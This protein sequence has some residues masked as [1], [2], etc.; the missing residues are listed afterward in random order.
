[1]RG[2]GFE[3]KLM[4]LS[5][6]GTIGRSVDFKA[7]ASFE[8]YH[9]MRAV[10]DGKYADPIMRFVDPPVDY[11]HEIIREDGKYVVRSNFGAETV[12]TTFDPSLNFLVTKVLRTNSGYSS[13]F[14]VIDAIKLPNGS[15]IPKKTYCYFGYRADEFPRIAHLWWTTDINCKPLIS[16]LELDLAYAFQL[17][18]PNGNGVLMIHPQEKFSPDVL[19]DVYSAI[20]RGSSFPSSNLGSAPEMQP[21]F[22]GNSSVPLTYVFASVAFV[23]LITI[24]ML[25]WFRRNRCL[26]L[27]SIG[28]VVAAVF[29]SLERVSA[30]EPDS[31]SI[32]RPSIFLCAR[33]VYRTLQFSS[34][35]GIASFSSSGYQLLSSEQVL[36]EL[37]VSESMRPEILKAMESH[38]IVL[39]SAIRNS[40]SNTFI[41]KFF[42]ESST[43]LINEEGK[44]RTLLSAKQIRRLNQID[45]YLALRQGGA[46][47]LIVLLGIGGDP[48]EEVRLVEISQH[49]LELKKKAYDKANQIWLKTLDR[50]EGH[51]SHQG[52]IHDWWRDRRLGFEDTIYADLV[53]QNVAKKNFAEFFG[54]PIHEIGFPEVFSNSVQL[55]SEAD[56]QWS[57][58]VFRDMPLLGNFSYLVSTFHFQQLHYGENELDL[59]AE[60]VEALNKVSEHVY[61][62][63][64]SIPDLKQSQFKQIALKHISDAWNDILLPRQRDFVVDLIRGQ[65]RT[66][67]G[68]L[69]VLF[70][71]ELDEK[72]KQSI[73]QEFDRCRKQL[74]EIEA[75][76]MTDLLSVLKKELDMPNLITGQA[77]PKYLQPSLCLLELHLI[78]KG[79]LPRPKNEIEQELQKR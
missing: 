7:T 77:R 43:D 48:I 36:S 18:R 10:G 46:E 32:Y 31:I 53:C 75:Q 54:E 58:K 59:S 12:A 71:P 65:Y 4:E 63:A 34:E 19:P 76:L 39:S 66:M 79:H 42:R 40:Q 74:L 1:M 14:G 68:P 30:D 56:G 8:P 70:R 24:S 2:H 72:T 73:R 52:Q 64:Y 28:F 49:E 22:D 44:I 35:T 20:Q 67:A 45:Q 33:P 50:I 23:L 15:C 25:N 9:G 38:L 3:L 37:Q 27:I 61:A 47:Y 5:R 60:Q 41:E 69:E 16:E 13:E 21:S 51:F 55:Q 29:G 11:R 78:A 6:G 57:L 26:M 17:P 62:E